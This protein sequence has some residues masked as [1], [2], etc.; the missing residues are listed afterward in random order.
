[1]AE[2]HRFGRD[3]RH[4]GQHHLAALAVLPDGLGFRE[5]CAIVDADDVI[6]RHFN[7]RDV[8]ALAMCNGHNIGKV[9]FALGIVVAN[10]IQQC[11]CF[12][13][14]HGHQAAIAEADLLLGVCR[15][16]FLDNGDQLV[17][18]L[19]QAAIAMRT[20]RAETDH[21]DI[22]AIGQ[23]RTRRL[24]DCASI[25]GVSPNTISRSS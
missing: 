9:I 1:M 15:F 7:R 10:G 3:Q 17:T 20:Y 22:R 14:A 21:H 4:T 11:Q 16:L 19:D 18:I 13:S 2:E 6:D 25:S 12:A 24:Q 5:F 23:A 8:Q